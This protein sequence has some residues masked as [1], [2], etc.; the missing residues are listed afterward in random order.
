M[1]SWYSYDQAAREIFGS[2]A[3]GDTIGNTH[4]GTRRLN[5]PTAAEVA[6]GGPS[7][8]DATKMV[9]AAG[10]RAEK[11]QAA[12]LKAS[13]YHGVSWS[14]TLRRW[15]AVLILPGNQQRKLGMHFVCEQSAA[16]EWDRAVRQ[17]LGKDAHGKLSKSS[18]SR[19]RYKQWLLNFPTKE[20]QQRLRQIEAARQRTRSQS[21]ASPVPIGGLLR[22]SLEVLHLAAPT[23][24]RRLEYKFEVAGGQERWFPG[25][26]TKAVANTSRSRWT[27]W[28]D[29]SFDDG[30]HH[31]VQ[32][33]RHMQG[34]AWRWAIGTYG[35]DREGGGCA[36]QA[37]YTVTSLKA[38][39]EP[40]RN[41]LGQFVRTCW[42][43]P[44]F[45]KRACWHKPA[46]TVR[47]LPAKKCD[48]ARIESGLLQVEAGR[49]E[50]E[51]LEQ[52]QEEEEEGGEKDDAQCFGARGSERLQT[53]VFASEDARKAM[54]YYTWQT[55]DTDEPLLDEIVAGRRSLP[56]LTKP[57]GV[58]G[59]GAFASRELAESEFIGG[60]AG[61]IIQVRASHIILDEL[62]ARS[63]RSFSSHLF[64]LV[65]EIST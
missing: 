64:S 62:L 2:R 36:R 16:K 17:L 51:E 40:G 44:G 10:K 13:K 59:V 37:A 45:P 18:G 47:R 19:V 41:H 20:E 11:R 48:H 42:R 55:E 4:G 60:Y 52:A 5:F 9:A 35:E 23:V 21:S 39:T 26:I 49:G 61:E 7:Y 30:D 28:F 58:A 22:D 1:C 53:C 33:L 12:G 34:V 54:R 24:G 56:I 14:K 63:N 27:N 29:V 65:P 8:P 15:T 46:E 3:H 50:Q 57:S 32:I 6:K 25:V 31:C 38:R 43:K